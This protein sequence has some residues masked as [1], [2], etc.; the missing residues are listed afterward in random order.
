MP[1]VAPVS[2]LLGGDA[3]HNAGVARS[4]FDGSLAGPVRDAVLVNAAAALVASAPP[5][6]GD[7]AARLRAGI[8][9]A[10]VALDDGS[11]N[12]L[13]HRWVE[14]SAALV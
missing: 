5:D 3:A 11:A 6:G 2:A 13:L 1:E 8:A 7:L 14:V 12:R 10:A 9:R 4:L